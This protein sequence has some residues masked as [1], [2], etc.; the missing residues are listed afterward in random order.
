[1]NPGRGK[2]TTSQMTST[3]LKSAAVAVASSY[4]A[5]ME[6]IKIALE[7]VSTLGQE[8]GTSVRITIDSLSSLSK[9][10]TG[11]EGH[12]TNCGI[13]IWK[14]VEKIG[15]CTFVWVPAHCRLEGNECADVAAGEATHLAQDIRPLTLNTAKAVI[16]K[17]RR[18]K[19]K[20]YLQNWATTMKNRPKKFLNRWEEVT[21]NQLRTGHSSLSRADLARF[22]AIEDPGCLDCGEP[23]T[24]N[25]ILSCQR[26]AHIRHE[27]N[28]R[29][30]DMESLFNNHGYLFT[31]LRRMGGAHISA[32]H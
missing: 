8:H 22:G 16:K 4:E 3:T 18:P 10:A 32:E 1:M 11:P 9:L 23:G 26:G 30:D 27:L 21:W 15:R 6:A 2:T 14:A 19:D 31:C 17:K 20:S 28:G 29:D 12:D 7:Y 13:T 24:V 5:E 25:H